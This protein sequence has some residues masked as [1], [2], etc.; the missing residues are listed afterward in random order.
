MFHSAILIF[1][2]RTF[3]NVYAPDILKCSGHERPGKLTKMGICRL[4]GETILNPYNP[5][6][7]QNLRI[8]RLCPG[9]RP[10]RASTQLHSVC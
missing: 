3:L 6:N 5:R 1:K 4:R 10:I 9:R 2:Q 8:L 7:A